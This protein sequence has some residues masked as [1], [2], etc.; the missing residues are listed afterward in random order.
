MVLVEIFLDDIVGLVGAKNV[1]DS[2][3]LLEMEEHTIITENKLGARRM[4]SLSN[5]EML[6]REMWTWNSSRIEPK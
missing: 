2:E 5:G 1:V 4:Q 3:N 6:I